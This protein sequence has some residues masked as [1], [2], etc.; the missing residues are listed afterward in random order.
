MSNKAKS[1]KGN[2][3]SFLATI[4]N[5]ELRIFWIAAF[6]GWLCF[7]FYT[8]LHSLLTEY[9]ENQYKMIDPRLT[10]FVPLMISIFIFLYT[11]K[12]MSSEK[13]RKAVYLA[14]VLFFY[15]CFMEFT[16]LYLNLVD[17]TISFMYVLWLGLS[18]SES[19][20][21][22]ADFFTSHLQDRKKQV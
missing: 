1:S 10:A 7:G 12:V 4:K 16:S 18:L 6:L 5:P 21:L 8:V 22:S 17:L 13:W 2:F 14:N 9:V 3:R 19:D 11:K 15:G 20:F